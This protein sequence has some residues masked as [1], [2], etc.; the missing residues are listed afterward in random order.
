MNAPVD[1]DERTVAVE[2]ESYR[3]AYQVLSFGILV[4]VGYR[5]LLRGEAAWDLLS[6]VVL[7]G[8]VA[9][10]YQWSGRVLTRR[11]LVNGLAAM[12]AA[13]AIAA[14]VVWLRT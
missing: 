7:A 11:W 13:A 4:V 6:L 3:R 12:L 5:S 2:N 10:A 8:A 14:L 1:R 9:A